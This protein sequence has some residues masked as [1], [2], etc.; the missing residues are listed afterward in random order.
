MNEQELRGLVRSVI[1]R[2]GTAP[3]REATQTKSTA[4]TTSIAARQ[5]MK[6][7]AIFQ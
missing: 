2:L 4:C 7:M 6:P 5:R 3:D 1:A